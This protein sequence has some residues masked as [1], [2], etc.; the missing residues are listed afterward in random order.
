MRLTSL[1]LPSF[2]F[3]ACVCVCVRAQEKKTRERML[4]SEVRRLMREDGDYK[5]YYYTPYSARYFR[6]HRKIDMWEGEHGTR[7]PD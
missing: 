5:A 7:N 1:H 3:C 2:F 6:V 4:R